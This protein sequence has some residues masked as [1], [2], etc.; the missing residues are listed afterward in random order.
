ME[1]DEKVE[2]EIIEQYR[3]RFMDAI[4]DDLNMPL[5]MG[6][7]WEIVRNNI[8]SK[9]FAD[10]LIELD[11][12][13]GLDIKNSKKY[14]EEQAKIDLPEEIEKLIE[15]RKIARENKDWAESDRIRDELKEKGYI[16]KDTK[17]GMN[18]ELI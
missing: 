7:V 17:D 10:L 15:K 16:V 12:V 8:K 2:K 4:N 6:I 9:Q 5:A 11:N 3:N 18:I 14:I 13:L 1:S